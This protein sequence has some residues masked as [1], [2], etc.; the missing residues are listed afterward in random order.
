MRYRLFMV[1]QRISIAFTI[2]AVVSLAPAVHA[3]VRVGDRAAKLTGAKDGKGKQIDLRRY[4]K[5]L[6]LITFGASWCKPCKRELPKLQSLAK[7]YHG[8][9][10]TVIAVNIDKKTSKGRKFMNDLAL[11]NIVKAYDSAGASVESYDPPKMPS[12]YFV[13]SGIV[14]AVHAGYE[15][16]DYHKWI[17]T[18]TRLRASSK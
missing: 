9:G 17:K 18:V 16:G 2:L 7:K 3:G 1:M 4:R 11:P 10:V 14:R 5:D 8:K 12:I 13:A 15:R 6:V